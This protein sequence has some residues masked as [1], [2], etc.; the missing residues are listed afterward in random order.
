MNQKNRVQ[1]LLGGNLGDRL[2]NLDLAESLIVT[3]IGKAVYKSAIYET[4]PWGFEDKHPFLN[5]LIIVETPLTPAGVLNE[6]KSIEID[7]GRAKGNLQWSSR[8]IDIDILFYEEI[9]V[10]KADLTIPHPRLHERRFALEPLLESNPEFIHP[11]TKKSVKKLY[12]ECTDT[13]EVIIF[14][15]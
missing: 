11:L 4:E 9:I 5:Q 7:M 3:R 2:K 13:S 10:K 1:L 6:I 8:I 15:D 12:S 14:S